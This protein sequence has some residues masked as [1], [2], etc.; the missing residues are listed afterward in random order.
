MDNR[1]IQQ[2]VGGWI[3]QGNN[4]KSLSC[5]NYSFLGRVISLFFLPGQWSFTSGSRLNAVIQRETVL[6]VTS[7]LGMS[8]LILFPSIHGRCNRSDLAFCLAVLLLSG[9]MSIV[10]SDQMYGESSF[11]WSE[12][13]SRCLKDLVRQYCSKSTLPGRPAN[14]WW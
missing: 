10:I 8:S 12:E 1:K 3:A 14:P 7:C 5:S 2:L 13:E 4:L 6:P 11:V 9:A